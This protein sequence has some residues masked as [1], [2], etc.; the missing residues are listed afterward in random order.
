MMLL[1]LLRKVRLNMFRTPSAIT[2]ATI[3]VKGMIAVKVVVMIMNVAVIMA[4]SVNAVTITAKASIAAIKKAMKA[5]G[6][7]TENESLRGI[8]FWV[9]DYCLGT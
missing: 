2:M 5:A 3:T 8:I 6:V 7:I 9:S 4:R 1:K